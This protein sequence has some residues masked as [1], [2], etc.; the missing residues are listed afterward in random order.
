MPLF[1]AILATIGLAI[2]KL[3]DFFGLG[4]LAW[5]WVLAPI[6]GVLLAAFVLWLLF[7]VG[8]FLF[9]LVFDRRRF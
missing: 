9:M 7:V 3:N 6:W 4:D 2:S 8:T 1:L 5:L